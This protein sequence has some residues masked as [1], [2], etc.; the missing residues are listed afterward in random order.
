[1][2]LITGGSFQGK[3]DFARRRFDLTDADIQFCDEDTAAIDATRR[4]AAHI[5]CFAL[6]RVRAGV[7]P[8]DVLGL[9][10]RRLDG[11][12]LIA[13]D[14]SGGVVPVDATLRA[15]REACGR[16]NIALA[17]RADEVW[18]LYCGLPQQLK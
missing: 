11:M 5:E 18:R 2:I 9:G 14:V 12:I 4:C 17:A 1:M 13:T 10:E 7:E 8:L 3:V 16:M 6:N 15:W